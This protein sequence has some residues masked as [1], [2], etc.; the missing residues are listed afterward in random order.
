ML[1]LVSNT[2]SYNLIHR[3]VV[4][5]SVF[6]TV[7]TVNTEL[8]INIDINSQLLFNGIFVYNNESKTTDFLNHRL[9][10]GFQQN[11]RLCF[12]IREAG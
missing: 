4:V 12:L 10:H 11:N 5:I 3:P 6:N 7:V 2:R 1:K 8:N 9:E